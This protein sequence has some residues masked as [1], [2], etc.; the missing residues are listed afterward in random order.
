M[1]PRQ[2]LHGVR[3]IAVPGDGPMVVTVQAND[4]GEHMRIAGVALRPRGGV[5]LSVAGG[6]QPVD[7]EHLVASCAQGGHPRA[8][9]GLKADNDLDSDFLRRQLAPCRRSR[10]GHQRMQPGDALQALSQPS[11]N[12]PSTV[13]VHELDIVVSFSPVVS[14]EQ[15]LQQPPG[16]G[17]AR[18]QHAG[19]SAT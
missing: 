14:D 17:P 9:V 2:E 8:A 16:V 12:Q 3:K 15:Q 10:F 5:P 18:S 4:L 1:R 7:R 13:V 6:R 11:P 19:T